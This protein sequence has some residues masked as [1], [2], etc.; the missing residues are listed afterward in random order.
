MK[1]L[2]FWLLPPPAITTLTTETLAPRPSV[3]VC[4]VSPARNASFTLREAWFTSDT[5]RFFLCLYLYLLV[6]ILVLYFCPHFGCWP[7][8]CAASC[9]QRGG[10]T[11][12]NFL[13]FLRFLF[14][15]SHTHLSFER[16]SSETILLFSDSGGSEV[17]VCENNTQVTVL[18]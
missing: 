4:C 18:V 12:T 7:A 6:I 15:I 5:A 8:A 10:S 14:F 16:E 2:D 17:G 9:Q 1:R 11:R 3:C 13:Y